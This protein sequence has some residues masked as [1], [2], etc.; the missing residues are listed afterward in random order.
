MPAN[1]LGSPYTLK[2]KDGTIID[3]MALTIIGPATSW[4]EIVGLPFIR[5]L[6]TIAVDGKESSIVEEIFDKTSEL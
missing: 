5:R 1:N 3:F 4:F 6:K 2:G